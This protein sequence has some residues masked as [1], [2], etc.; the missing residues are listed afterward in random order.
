MAEKWA[1]RLLGYD[2]GGKAPFVSKTDALTKSADYS[3]LGKRLG[4]KS[5]IRIG[6][7]SESAEDS[8][9]VMYGILITFC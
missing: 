9:L 7:N 6:R 4:F 1:I 5:D 2:G 3:T 8:A